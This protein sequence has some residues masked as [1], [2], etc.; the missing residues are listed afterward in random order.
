MHTCNLQSLIPR[1]QGVSWSANIF[2]WELEAV[3]MDTCMEQHETPN[4][5][6][7]WGLQSDKFLAHV[8][9]NR[10]N[11]GV[12]SSLRGGP[13]MQPQKIFIIAGWTWVYVGSM[14]KR[15]WAW[16]A[17]VSF[18][19]INTLER[20]LP[21]QA[22]LLEINKILHLQFFQT[23]SHICKQESIR[24]GHS[25]ILSIGFSKSLLYYGVRSPSIVRLASEVDL[26]NLPRPFGNLYTRRVGAKPGLCTNHL[27]VFSGRLREWLQ[28]L[29][30]RTQ[31]SQHLP[32]FK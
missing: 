9:I 15:R 29:I 3:Q 10:M 31:E 13:G 30:M 32:L 6:S 28:S 16:H 17:I 12:G 2:A 25:T 11:V 4:F 27:R 8:F 24:D 19:L 20:S 23:Y 22:G 7:R 21:F 14:L 1:P 26:R 5:H 18:W